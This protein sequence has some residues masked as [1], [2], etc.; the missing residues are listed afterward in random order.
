M[1]QFRLGQRV[2]INE[3]PLPFDRKSSSDA[4]SRPISAGRTHCAGDVECAGPGH[5]QAIIVGDINGCGARVSST[6]AAP[7]AY[8]RNL[9]VL[10]V[11]LASQLRLASEFSPGPW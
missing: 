5:R 2:I 7:R 11:P 3:P 9:V 6:R 10:R 1:G 8:A 4:G